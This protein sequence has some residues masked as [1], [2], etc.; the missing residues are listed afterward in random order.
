MP[1]ETLWPGTLDLLESL[2]RQ[3]RAE[4]M[5]RGQSVA[6]TALVVVDEIGEPVRPE[7][8]SDR[9]RRLAREAGVPVIRLHA[10]RH[11]LGD[12]LGAAGVAPADGAR[13]L[14]H[15]TEVYLS[16]YSHATSAGVAA[17]AEQVARVLHG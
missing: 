13:I 12:M 1:V 6:D 14:G 10:T 4:A 2:R 7:W 5:R 8:Y 11:T 15:S 9:F 3:Q 17:A 16:T